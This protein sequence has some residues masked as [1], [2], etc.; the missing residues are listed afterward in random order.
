VRPRGA[1]FG[2]SR[3]RWLIWPGYVLSMALA[4]GMLILSGAIVRSDV[5]QDMHA[6]L[7]MGQRQSW[8]HMWPQLRT[9]TVS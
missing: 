9:L 7:L 2:P 5:G 3:R 4:V 1:L 6:Y 8:D